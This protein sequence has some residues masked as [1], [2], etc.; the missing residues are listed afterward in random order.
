MYQINCHSLLFLFLLLLMAVGAQ[1]SSILSVLSDS[2]S[3]TVRWTLTRE[4]ILS[5]RAA[6]PK[7]DQR[8]RLYIASLGCTGQR[9][10]Q[11]G[12]RVKRFTALQSRIIPVVI[13][14]R[15][16][17]N[18]YQPSTHRPPV[19]ITVSR[20]PTSVCS[21]VSK[22]TEQLNSPVPSLYTF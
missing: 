21:T 12:G 18:R 6:A 10:G 9:R 7:L 14:N 11:R 2:A 16:K 1:Y 19:R 20:T 22:H 3:R 17:Y 8:T 4:A 5:L 13:G 15:P